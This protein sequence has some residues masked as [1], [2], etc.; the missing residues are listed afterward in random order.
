MSNG[1]FEQRQSELDLSKAFSGSSAT[2]DLWARS[3]L[4]L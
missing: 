1:N 2:M 3:S 4:N